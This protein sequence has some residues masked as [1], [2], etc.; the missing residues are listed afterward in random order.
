[1]GIKK[2]LSELDPNQS[3]RDANA[4]NESL[5]YINIED[6]KSISGIAI[7]GL[8]RTGFDQPIQRDHWCGV[9]CLARRPRQGLMT[10]CACR[11]ESSPLGTAPKLR[12]NRF[13]YR[14][15]TID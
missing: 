15:T 10:T 13:K 6:I 14:S 1:M 2:G 4:D 12:Q 9:S 11:R 7:E 5:I 3:F 8:P